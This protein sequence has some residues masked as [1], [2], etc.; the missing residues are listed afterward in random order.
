ML[1]DVYKQAREATGDEVILLF[2]VGDYYEAL[3]EDAVTISAVLGI[4]VMGTPIRMAGFPHHCLD[5]YLP[6][7]VKAGY[8]V[9][10]VDEVNQ[11]T[12]G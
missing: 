2:R 12:K 10:V 3:H 5:L 6:K 8:R 9:A 11:E 7:L 1:N 4:G